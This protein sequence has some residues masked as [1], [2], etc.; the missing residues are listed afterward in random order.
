MR[1]AYGK[2]GRSIPLT[3]AEA[4]NVG[5]D[6]EVVN[7]LHRLLQDGH[8]VH[9]IGRN[10]GKFT[11]P[12]LVNY[13]ASGGTFG[14]AP[15]ASRHRDDAFQRYDNWLTQHISLLPRFDV[16]VLWLGQHGS[17]LHPVPAV[18]ESKKG[19]F[20]NPLVSDCNYGYPLVKMVNQCNARPMWLCPDPRNMIKF[21][22]LW[23]PGQRDIL[24]QY[25]TSKSNTFY[26]ERIGTLRH[27]PTRYVYSGIE[28]LALPVNHLVR[29]RH[30]Q[31][32]SEL[33]FGV[34]V[35][36]GYSNLGNKGRCHL[37]KTWLKDLGDYEIFGTWSEGSQKELGRVIT[38]V[39]LLEVQPTLRRW[40]STITFPATGGGWATA[41]PWEAF[42]A[43]TVCFKHP[44][45]DSQGHIYSREFMPEAL[46]TFLCPAT[47]SGLV[48]RV[49]SLE[50][51]RTW[52]TYVELQWEYLTFMRKKLD[53][54]YH[55]VREAMIRYA[56]MDSPVGPDE[57]RYER[58]CV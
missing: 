56:A 53:N 51:E 39:D 58:G 22:D 1:V 52:H 16:W 3:I 20:T 48:E 35:N 34:L 14:S 25:N 26:D 13:W 41:K 54:G 2:L 18:Q 21:R 6:I 43:G 50:D 47:V 19:S 17:S 29:E 7:L 36:E 11:H 38:S 30:L 27:G 31:N 32:P 45:Y 33:P 8:T 24:A 46:R 49:R 44:G 42:L 5:G 4:S 15:P 10:Q 12:N 55:H 40:R 23:E 9:L 57:G 37:V 28:M